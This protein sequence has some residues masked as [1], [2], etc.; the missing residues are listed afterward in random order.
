MPQAD[1]DVLVIGAGVIGLTTAICLAEAGLTVLVV[2]AEQPRQTTSAAAGALW[3][4]H[5][6]GMDER[7]GRWAAIT[8]ERLEELRA[9]RLGAG[10]LAGIVRTVPGIAATATPSSEPPEYA[11]AGSLTPCLPGEVPAGYATAW[12]LAAPLIAMPDYL[13]YLAERLSRAGG[14]ITVGAP[15][16]TLAD[17]RDAAPEARVIVNCT[18]YGARHLV[19]DH[20]VEAVRGQA[21][22]VRNP[23][24]AEFFVGSGAAHWPLTYLFP[25]D[26]VVLLGG[27]EEHGSSSREPDASTAERIVAACAAIR[28]ELRDAPVL[29]HRVGLRPVRSSVRLEAEISD[30]VTVVHSY[31]HGGAGVT[32]SWGCA[33]DAAHLVLD[34]LG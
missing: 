12:R 8:L 4:P 29:E 26:D 32:L 28:P 7:I 13:D 22:V 11:A 2:S 1:A 34:V 31:G 3:G 19:P 33:E 23:G 18:G 10:A 17:A 24:I 30:G 6:V 14:T 16:T 21:V 20:D 27:T 9:P 5:L 15:L 25:H